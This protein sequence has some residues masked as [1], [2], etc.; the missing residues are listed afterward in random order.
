MFQFYQSLCRYIKKKT[1]NENKIIS[2]VYGE[3][4]KDKNII[5]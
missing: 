3:T 1:P 5:E 2:V 4:L